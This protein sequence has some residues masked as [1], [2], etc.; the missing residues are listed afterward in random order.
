[1]AKIGTP[2]PGD[3]GSPA[4]RLIPWLDGETVEIDTY[5]EMHR[6]QNQQLV[7]DGYPLNP[8]L[9]QWFDN[10]PNEHREPL[11]VKDWWGLPFI[12]SDTWEEREKHF[13]SVQARHREERNE[14]VVSDEKLEADIAKS[15]AGWLSHYPSGTQFN[16]RCL[17]GGAW[18][19]STNWGCFDSL[20]QALAC[21]KQGP[22]W[23]SGK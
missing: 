4:T 9:R 17:D 3:Q 22:S 14:F 1:M 20:E 19:R 6:P 7:G 15:K 11:E 16:V 10:T 21:C 12:V 18:D 8:T 5:Q 13:R 23:R 2:E